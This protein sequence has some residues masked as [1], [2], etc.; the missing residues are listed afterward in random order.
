MIIYAHYSKS[1]NLPMIGLKDLKNYNPIVEY[2]ETQYDEYYYYNDEMNYTDLLNNSDLVVEVSCQD[3]GEQMA[4]SMLRD[5]KVEKVIKGNEILEKDNIFIY[6]PSYITPYNDWA[7][8]NGYINMEKNEKYFLFLKKVNAPQIAPP[9]YS[10]A[11][12]LASA[13]FGKYKIGHSEKVIN[14]NSEF[15]YTDLYGHEVLFTNG[16]KV[17]VYNAILEDLEK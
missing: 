12:Y 17:Q 1:T 5:C 14:K 6:E 7:I 15:K 4:Y 10:E 9:M 16:K 8:V 3:N 2:D 13:E 11:Y